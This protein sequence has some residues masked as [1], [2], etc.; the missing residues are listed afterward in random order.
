MVE[1]EPEA[2]IVEINFKTEQP[3]KISVQ[4][5]ASSPSPPAR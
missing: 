5:V 4:S 2:E 1:A 3:R